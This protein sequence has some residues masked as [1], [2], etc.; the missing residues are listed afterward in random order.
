[1]CHNWEFYSEVQLSLVRRRKLD[2]QPCSVLKVEQIESQLAQLWDGFNMPLLIGANLNHRCDFRGP[3]LSLKRAKREFR[4]RV[5]TVNSE[6]TEP[7]VQRKKASHLPVR[8]LF[9]FVVSL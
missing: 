9:T 3:Y 5:L 1:M 4:E 8:S 6:Y 2:I 7:C